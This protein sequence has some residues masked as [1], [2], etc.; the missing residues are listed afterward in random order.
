MALKGFDRD[1]IIEYVPEYSNNRDSDDPC[2]VR[3]KFVSFARVQGYAREINARVQ[4]KGSNVT[5]V[6]QAIQKKQFVESVQSVS[7]YFIQDKEVTGAEEFYETADTDLILEVCRAMESQSK[8]DEGQK[9]NFP[10][11]S[12]SSSDTPEAAPSIAEDVVT[13]INKAGTAATPLHFQ[14]KAKQ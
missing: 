1:E 3:L 2:I 8:L 5:K 14:E 9:I 6:T 11:A 12:D 7:G 4:N 13:E 10:S